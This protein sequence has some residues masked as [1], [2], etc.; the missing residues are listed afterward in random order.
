MEEQEFSRECFRCARQ[1]QNPGDHVWRWAA[2]HFGLDLIVNL[3]E[4]TLRFKR[5]NRAESEHI[6][7]NHSKHHIILKYVFTK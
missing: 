2:F 7:A 5:F 3:D 4:T 1:I 6:K